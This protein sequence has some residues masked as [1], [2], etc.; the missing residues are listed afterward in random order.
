MVQLDDGTV[1]YGKP[2]G[3]WVTAKTADKLDD[4][5]IKSIGC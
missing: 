3:Q 2:G 5:L 4:A 1:L